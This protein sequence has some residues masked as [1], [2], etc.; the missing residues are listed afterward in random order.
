MLRTALALCLA[1]VAGRAG[2]EVRL[3]IDITTS[4]AVPFELAFDD[5]QAAGATATSL[6]V[7]W[8]DLE[9]G[10]TYAPEFDWPAIANQVYP[11]TEMG[12]SLTISVIDTVADR[13]PDDLRGKAWDDP[14]V[15]RRFH[16]FL[17]AVLARMPDTDLLSLTIGNEVDGFLAAPGDVAAYARFVSAAASHVAARDMPV[18]TKLTFGAMK[19]PDLW[20]PL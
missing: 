11:Q 16:L 14:D 3:S 1:L 5:I 15:I 10:G 19:R 20:A 9:R 18:G 2:A 6:T 7:F 4:P 13:R 17:D 12:V 8:D